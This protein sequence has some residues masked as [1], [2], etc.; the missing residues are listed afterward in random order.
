MVSCDTPEPVTQFLVGLR[1]DFGDGTERRLHD[2]IAH[3][4][5]VVI[6]SGHPP[7]DREDYEIEKRVMRL[8]GIPRAMCRRVVE[9]LRQVQRLRLLRELNLAEPDILLDDLRE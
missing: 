4:V 2:E 1:V 9:V 7:T 5:A 8:Y 3:R 6:A